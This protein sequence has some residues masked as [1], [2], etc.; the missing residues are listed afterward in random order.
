[1]IVVQEPVTMP[2]KVELPDDLVLKMQKVAVPLV[3]TPLSVIERGIDALIEQEI[4]ASEPATSGTAL[5]PAD[6]PPSLTFSKPTAI[7]L[8]GEHL[9]KNQLYWN[10]LLFRVVALAAPKLDDQQFEHSLL[11]NHR[12]DKYEEDGYRWIEEA[13]MSV[14]G[15]DANAAWKATVRLVK[16]AG[17]SVDVT[18]R[19]ADKDEASNP[20]KFGRMSYKP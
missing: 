6:N 2:M 3:D 14:Q 5:Y 18:F 12:A 10:L 4:G 1:M 19:W 7:T 20:G 17:L 9:P 13:K 8:E 16:A 11:I 15:G